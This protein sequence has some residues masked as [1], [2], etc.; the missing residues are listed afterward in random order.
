MK[1]GIITPVYID[2]VEYDGELKSCLTIYTDGA[3]KWRVI[4]R[5]NKKSVSATIVFPRS[6]ALQWR[7]GIGTL[8][9][10]NKT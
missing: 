7:H 1:L 9:E 10:E 6:I 2:G 8:T 3:E 5:K 4:A